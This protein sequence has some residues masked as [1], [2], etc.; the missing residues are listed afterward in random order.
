M[1]GH[2]KTPGGHQ[3]SGGPAVLVLSTADWDAPIW[4]NKQ[5]VAKALA[6]EF[7]VWFVEPVGLRRPTLTPADVRRALRRALRLILSSGRSAL[8][9]PDGLRVVSPWAIPRARSQMARIWNEQMLRRQV[10]G[11]REHPGPKVL[12][13]FTPNTEGLANACDAAVYHCVDLMEFSPG[14]DAAHVQHHE[15]LL[16]ARGTPAIAS[17]Q[18]VLDHLRAV[19]FSKVE[20]WENVADVERFHA[21]DR[22]PAERRP[23]RVVFAGHV[24]PE[25]VDF[26]LLT[27]VAVDTRFELH[28]VGPWGLDGTQ[29]DM[30]E[31]EAAGAIL[32]G[33]MNPD[34]LAALL[35]SAQIGLIPYVLNDS[36]NG[37]FPLK[38]YEYL[39]AG[40]RVVST[41]IPSVVTASTRTPEIVVATPETFL[42]ALGDLVA[43]PTMQLPV[44]VRAWSGHSWV[45]RS[46]AVREFVHTL[47]DGVSVT[48]PRG[49]RVTSSS[50]RGSA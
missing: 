47:V 4:T 25:K 39:A 8:P 14:A 40:L 46:V 28:I 43:A 24:T 33:V 20:L 26:D 15:A 42:D 16:A 36:T 1:I 44:P 21:A 41:P 31:L 32:H 3:E 27:S 48:A 22:P 29:V 7:P 12:W 35:G 9:R 5:H 2:P 18:V 34:A 23:G 49:S 19:G 13:T 45:D 11:W 10:R 37:V 50:P 38:L 17:S 30:S 6:A